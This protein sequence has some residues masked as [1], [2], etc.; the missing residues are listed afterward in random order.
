MLSSAAAAVPP[1]APFCTAYHGI[2]PIRQRVYVTG[3]ENERPGRCRAVETSNLSRNSEVL[4]ARLDLGLRPLLGGRQAFKALEQLLLGHA[5]DR[6][7]GI[8]GIHTR[9]GRT[10][11]RYGIE[12][13]LI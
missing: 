7:L 3:A 9:A 13:R 2:L 4:V 6:H 5:L 11:Q 1:Q 10:N 8:V 12:F